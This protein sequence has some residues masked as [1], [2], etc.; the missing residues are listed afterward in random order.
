MGGRYCIAIGLI[1]SLFVGM[2]A[3][4]E[5]Q[6][7]SRIVVEKSFSDKDAVD[8]SG[9]AV[10]GDAGQDFL[11]ILTLNLNQSGWFKVNTGPG[12]SI[13]VD[14]TFRNAG[15]STRVVYRITDVKSGRVL[16]ED[17]ISGSGSEARTVARRLCDAIVKAVKHV[18]GMATSRIVMVGRPGGPK[19]LFVTTSDGQNSS[20]LTRDKAYV[21]VRPRWTPDGKG[22]LYTS[23]HKGFS[24]I[25]EID[26]ATS[27]RKVVVSM[28][29]S[30]VGSSLSPDGSTLAFCASRDGN[31]ELYIARRSGG[32]LVRLT[33][34]AQAA[35]ASAA[36]APDGRRIVYVSNQ[37]LSTRAGQPQLFIMDM[38]SRKGQRLSLPGQSNESPDWGPD[39]RIVFA[40]RR[41]GFYQICIYNPQ[42]GEQTQ[43]TSEGVNSEDPSWAPDGRHI[44]CSRTF[45]G[46]AG[47]YILDTLGDPPI[48][49]T[50]S[51]ADW[52]SPDWAP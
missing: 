44:V 3:T 18:P 22:I 41:S 31:P 39:G 8:L 24:D 10:A 11:K 5:A 9:L 27:H 1:V 40:S 16:A 48:R 28:P 30:N 36:W 46:Q 19:C 25:Y 33:R 15:S 13:K 14:G 51:G 43:L 52:Y 35:E 20:Q 47:V 49:L 2:V 17:G 26:L 4:S 37:Y 6:S 32:G 42:T 12:G 7:D 50:K 34:T 29:G 45:G 21:V 23:D 38:G